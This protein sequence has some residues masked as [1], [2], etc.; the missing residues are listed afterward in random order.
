MTRKVVMVVDDDRD[1]L[2]LVER[3]LA[4]LDV[5]IVTRDRGY[6]VLNAVAERRP[7]LV[8]LDIM[9]PGLDGT[10]VAQLIRDDPELERTVIVFFSA[11]PPEQLHDLARQHG[12]DGFIPKTAGPRKLAEEV[13]RRLG[14]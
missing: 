3:S 6:G 5:E 9:M 1:I 8:L 11:L 14:I 7:D 4:G 13:S 2:R 10:S 12:A